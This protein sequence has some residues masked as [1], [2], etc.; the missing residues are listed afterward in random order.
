MRIR[1]RNEPSGF[2]PAALR[3]DTTRNSQILHW[4]AARLRTKA[5]ANQSLY[6][7]LCCRCIKISY[8]RNMGY[9]SNIAIIDELSASEGVFTTA[10]AER[11]GV[12]RNALAHAHKT[13]RLLRIAHGAYR[14][15]GVPSFETDEL[16]ALWKLTV[17]MAFSWGTPIRMGRHNDWWLHGCMHPWNR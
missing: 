6:W 2:R 1:S 17:P 15:S 7:L 8:N 14:L 10:Q 3:P 13:G 11:L 12:S 4:R 5:K 9:K 16:T